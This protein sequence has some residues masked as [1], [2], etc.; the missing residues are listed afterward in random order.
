MLPA[1]EAHILWSSYKRSEHIRRV[2][3]RESSLSRS[4]YY[5]MMALGCID[6]V[7]TLPISI[8]EVISE[9]APPPAIQFYPGWHAIHSDFSSIG[10]IP[11]S[12][13][14]K[15]LWSIVDVEWD[16]WINPLTA[17][18]FFALFGMTKE[19]R[20]FYRRCFRKI[21]T[22]L[23]LKWPAETSTRNAFS[24]IQFGTAEGGNGHGGSESAA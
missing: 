21:V 5:R 24:D 8:F 14:K 19:V 4:I 6:A 17:I 9:I 20:T 22:P 16:L 11:A 12:A 1:W 2:L 7:I 23:G 10:T 15:D 3:S 13:W 18:F